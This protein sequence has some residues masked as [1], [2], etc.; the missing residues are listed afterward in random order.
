MNSSIDIEK[1]GLAAEELFRSGGYYCSEAVVAAFRNTLSLPMPEEMV[2][3]AAGFAI[4][5]G[6]AKC[7]CGAVSGGVMVLGYFFGRRGPSTP[8]ADEVQKTFTLTK[9]LHDF[10]QT[11][12]G[13]ALL[14]YIDSGY[15]YGF[16]RHK[17][18]CISFTGEVARKVAEM[19][20][21]EKDG[22]SLTAGK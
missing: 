17:S 10:F 14:S 22:L 6:R 1:I 12:H 2:S 5:I 16:R 13:V 7:L 3:M 11:Q 9:E 15:G 18:Q 19:V 21:R 4:G 8:G 20:A